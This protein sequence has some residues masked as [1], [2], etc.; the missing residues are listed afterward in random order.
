MNSSVIGGVLSIPTR[1]NN[2]GKAKKTKVS[3]SAA[4]GG[5]RYVPLA[6]QI[7]DDKSVK[8]TSRVKV[9]NRKDRDDEVK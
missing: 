1:E 2:M 4:E 8:S 3:K 5:D 9:R 6:D 7:L